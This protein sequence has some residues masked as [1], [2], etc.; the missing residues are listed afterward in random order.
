MNPVTQFEDCLRQVSVSKLDPQ[1]KSKK[2]T[3]VSK[4]IERYL[5][6]VEAHQNSSTLSEGAVKAME[7]AKVQLRGLVAQA[8][9]LAEVYDREAVRV[10]VH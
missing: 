9:T 5:K 4:T 1:D 3:E 7:V 10:S 2:L 8:N 6:R